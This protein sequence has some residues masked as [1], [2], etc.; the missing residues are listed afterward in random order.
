MSVVTGVVVYVIVW[1]LLLFTVLPWG[2][3]PPDSSETGH[4]PSAPARPRLR[5][6]FLVTTALAAV[7]WL[8]IYAIVES[9]LISFRE[10]A[11]QQ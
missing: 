3:A 8:G 5:A 1:W 6:K 11:R 2:A 10:M 4:A 9:E 7:V